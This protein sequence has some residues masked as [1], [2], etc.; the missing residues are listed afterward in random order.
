MRRLRNWA[1]PAPRDVGRH[2][3]TCRE[4]FDIFDTDHNGWLSYDELRVHIQRQGGGAPLSDAEFDAIFA[5]S[6]SATERTR[7]LR[8]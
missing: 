1:F 8:I 2:S 7:T 4:A 5:E 3:L 6:A